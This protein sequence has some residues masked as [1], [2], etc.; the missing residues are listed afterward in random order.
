MSG[1][2]SRYKLVIDLLYF[3]DCT[4]VM[5]PSSLMEPLAITSSFNVVLLDNCDEMMLSF[6]TLAEN[7]LIIVIVLIFNS[8][9]NRNWAT[10]DDESLRS[11][12]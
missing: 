12:Q 9:G 5:T 11:T 1:F 7:I 2:L 8:C 4:N 3:N 10:Y 6:V